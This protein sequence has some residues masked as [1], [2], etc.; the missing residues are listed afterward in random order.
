M[1]ELGTRSVGEVVQTYVRA[2]W[3]RPGTQMS[4]QESARHLD[5]DL[6]ARI[7]LLGT[8]DERLLEVPPESVVA[9][10]EELEQ[11]AALEDAGMMERASQGHQQRATIGYARSGK[12]R[13]RRKG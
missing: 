6:R 1:T 9:K 8:D 5:P 7:D 12:P 2:K 4:A 10:I 13:R 3:K 11:E